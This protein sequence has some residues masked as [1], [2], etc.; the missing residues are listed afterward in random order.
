MENIQMMTHSLFEA[1]H[2]LAWT[3]LEKT[4]Y[5]WEI[6]GDLKA[7]ICEIGN[8][9][10]PRVYDHPRE[11]VWIAK[12]AEIAPTAFVGDAVIIGQHT[13][14]RHGAYIRGSALVGDGCVVGNSVELKNCVLFDRVQVPHFNYVGDSILGYKAH[15]GA[16][17]VTSNV[18]SDHAL[19]IIKGEG[20]C[21]PTGLKKMGA[22]LGDFVEVGCNAV[23]NPG[24]VIGQGCRVYP[25]ASVRGIIPPNHIVKAGKGTEIV[26]M[27]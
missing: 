16:G 17:A 24:C 14:V 11:G 22:M 13:Q 21:I 26:P 12:T 25:T 23:L 18:K 3:Y 2:T 4:T 7:M 6:L 20:V 5:P 19:V 9:L 8:T 1:G 10:D 15:M 27:A